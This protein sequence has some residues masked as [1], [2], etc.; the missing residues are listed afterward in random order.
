LLSVQLG[1]MTANTDDVLSFLVHLRPGFQI[2]NPPGLRRDLIPIP[3]DIGIVLEPH[4]PAILSEK[5]QND[6][7]ITSG[8]PKPLFAPSIEG[9]FSDSHDRWPKVFAVF[10][11]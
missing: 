3:R 5:R 2:P 6:Q 1:L 9:A 7:R 8:P 4:L 11:A 10:E